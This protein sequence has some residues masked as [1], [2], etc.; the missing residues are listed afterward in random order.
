MSG[1]AQVFHARGYCVQGSDASTSPL[2]GTL[3]SQGIQI[4]D[5]QIA[6]NIQGV[7]YL[8]MSSAIPAHNPEVVAAKALGIPILKRA[9]LLAGLMSRHKTVCIAGTHGKTTTTCLIGTLLDVAK[10]DP[11]VLNG[12]IMKR[13]GSNIRLGASPWMVVEADESDGT[14]CHLPADVAV[15]TNVDRDHMEFFKTEAHLEELFCQFL[16]QLPPDGL[17]IVCIDDEGISRIRKKLSHKPL[18]FY[19]LDAQADVRGENVRFTP[20]GMV[21]DVCFPNGQKWT[22]VLVTLFGLHNV[23]NTL[24]CLAVAWHLSLEEEVVRL[25]L[26]TF[27]GVGRRFTCTGISREITFI[28]DYAHHPKEI[29]AVLKA[30]RPL[31]KGRLIGICQPHRYS[32]LGALFEEFTQCFRGADE[33]LLLPVYGAGE[34]PQGIQS[35]DLGPRIQ[36]VEGGVQHLETFDAVVTHLEGRLKPGDMVICLGAGDITHLAHRLPLELC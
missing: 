30:A 25:A 1:L 13:Y 8:V 3:S 23:L 27:S 6:Q 33:L 28:D 31:V 14:L 34:A 18:L 36:N 11:T 10:M 21:F 26:E 29:E 7:D 12:G 15:V 22:D 16:G 19:G 2:L 20:Q 32:R 24:A 4:F 35:S 5:T 9:E 17:G